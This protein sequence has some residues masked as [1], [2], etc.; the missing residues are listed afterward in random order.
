MMNRG[1]AGLVSMLILLTGGCVAVGQPS[2]SEVDFGFDGLESTYEVAQDVTA[3]VVNKSDRPFFFYCTV[4]AQL[5]D[6]WREIMYS[7]D[8]PVPRMAIELK[9]IA[10]GERAAISWPA[11]R[12][13]SQSWGTGT[14]RLVV[15][16]SET[17]TPALSPLA[18]RSEPFVV[19]S[20][21]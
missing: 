13:R 21:R 19:E 16:V 15:F 2:Q 5:Q 4:E 9:R 6:Q 17:E 18:F 3:Y 12:R 1:A 7:I 10:S 20:E 8:Q 11:D 14:Y